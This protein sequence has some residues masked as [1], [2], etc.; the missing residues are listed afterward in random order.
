MTLPPLIGNGS[1]RR[2]EQRI[3]E[4]FPARVRAIDRDGIAFEA[5][6]VID[7]INT[8]GLYLRLMFCLTRGA[9]LSVEF[10]L[11]CSAEKAATSPR[12]KVKGEVVRVDPKPGRVWGVAITYKLQQFYFAKTE[13]LSFDLQVP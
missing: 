2:R 6:T 11:C 3:C 12:A 5:D 7:N 9:E 13:N 1:E 8:N 10:R 4:P